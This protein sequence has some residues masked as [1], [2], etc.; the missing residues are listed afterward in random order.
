VQDP[1]RVR[2]TLEPAC[3]ALPINPEQLRQHLQAGGDLQDLAAGALTRKGLRLAAEAWALRRSDLPPDNPLPDPKAEG[4][5]QELLAMLTQGSTI[6][7]SFATDDESESDHVVL[8]SPSAGR[9]RTRFAS[10]RA[11]MMACACRH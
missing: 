8:E 6:N 5:R 7:Y 4:E 9:E 1:D 10:R 3:Q 2:R 11:D